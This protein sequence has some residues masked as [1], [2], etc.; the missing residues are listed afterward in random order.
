M[1]RFF[2]HISNGKPY[3]DEAGEELR[4]AQEAWLTAKRLTRDIEDTLDMNARWEV[5]VT[6]T[7][8]HPLFSIEITGRKAR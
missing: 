1:P 2:F 5:E 6:D 4:D 7:D 8:G 3:R